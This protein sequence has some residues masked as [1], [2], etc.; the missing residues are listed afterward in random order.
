VVSDQMAAAMEVLS[1][2]VA[3][4]PA[5]G[6]ETVSPPRH[7]P[8]ETARATGHSTQSRTRSERWATRFGTL[9]FAA[10]CGWLLVNYQ[11]GRQQERVLAKFACQ[12]EADW[13][14]FDVYRLDLSKC[15]KKPGDNDLL[16]LD[17]FE[18]LGQLNLKGAPITDA[19][20]KHLYNMK[21]LW[22]VDLYDTQVTK[23]G[24]DELKRA[25]PKVNISWDS[26]NKQARAEER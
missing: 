15:V 5:V 21:T 14:G 6:A 22:S 7:N 19:G 13:I 10:A 12:P 1:R 25:L 9:A 8:T 24:V 26:W 17:L 23:K 3:V 11:D 2:Y 4:R 18:H 20:L 16:L